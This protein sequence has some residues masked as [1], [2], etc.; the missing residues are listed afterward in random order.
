MKK[1]LIFTA[2]LVS[3]GL[4]AFVMAIPDQTLPTGG[5]FYEGTVESTART[6]AITAAVTAQSD[7][8]AVTTATAYTPRWVGD[9]LIGGAG[10]GTNGVWI[11]KGTTTN[12]WVQCANAPDAEE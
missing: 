3:I 6:A 4:T 9:V 5:G 1:L 12:D 2:A 8:N 10:D 7:T 11:A